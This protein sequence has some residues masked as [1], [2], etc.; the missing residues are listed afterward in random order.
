MASRALF[1][2]K[3]QFFIAFL[4]SLEQVLPRAY[5]SVYR[6]KYRLK[7]DHNLKKINTIYGLN[8]T[9]IQ[10]KKLKENP[11]SPKMNAN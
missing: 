11:T 1:T 2:G 6:L 8:I 9:E 5:K 10:T 7:T 3:F 4:S